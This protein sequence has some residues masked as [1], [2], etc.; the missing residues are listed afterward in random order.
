[1]G[2]WIVDTNWYFNTAA[3]VAREASKLAGISVSTTSGLGADPTSLNTWKMAGNDAIG[4]EWGGKYDVVARSTLEGVGALVQG[5]SALAGQIHQAGVNHAEAEFRAGNGKFPFPQN[6]P[7]RPPVSEPVLPA[8][9]SSV[10]DNGAGLEEIIVGLAADVGIPVPNADYVKL[11]R[12]A[13]MWAPLAAGLT[14][15][16]ATISHQVRPPPEG[17]PDAMAFYDKVMTLNAPAAALSADALSLGALSGNF[18]TG[19]IG[20][21]VEICAEIQ[22]MVAE[23]GGAG[24]VSSL[25]TKVAGRVAWPVAVAKF[26]WRVYQCGQRIRALVEALNAATSAMQAYVP[27]LQTGM[28]A[29]LD[30]MKYVE[31]DVLDP[32]GTRTHHY[33]VP[34]SKWLSWLNYLH[35]GGHEWDWQRWSA[36]YDQLKENS[37]VG[38]IFDKWIGESKGYTTD[39]GWSSQYS[40]PDLAP[41]RIWDRANPDL[42]TLVEIKSGAL[43]RGQIP[44]DELAMQKGWTVIY[45]LNSNFSYSPADLKEIARLQERYGSR[46]IVNFN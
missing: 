15:A 13:T 37:A 22:S 32:D 26:A 44:A 6:L 31:I 4:T 33:R 46:F 45:E 42:Q 41:G 1:M 17:A 19:V 34:L 12:A 3:I 30:Q 25:P 16:V 18:S 24:A 11:G 20:M 35:R 9:G 40:N 36:S 28:K 10:G 2:I 43:A 39:Q 23:L 14:D 29:L 8:L 38:W 21:R 5:W 7:P 27:A